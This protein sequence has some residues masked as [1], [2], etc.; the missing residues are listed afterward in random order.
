MNVFIKKNKHLHLKNMHPD[1]DL[2][3]SPQNEF[4]ILGN[5]GYEC[6]YE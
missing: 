1:R 3:T 6:E 4:D 5:V 2:T